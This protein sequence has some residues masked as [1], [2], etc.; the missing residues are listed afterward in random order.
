MQKTPKEDKTNR[1]RILKNKR[2]IINKGETTEPAGKGIASWW[3]CLLWLSDEEGTNS[4]YMTSQGTLAKYPYKHLLG[5]VST[6]E[7]LLKGIVQGVV[8]ITYSWGK[9]ARLCSHMVLRSDLL[10]HLSPSLMGLAFPNQTRSDIVASLYD[11]H[12]RQHRRFGYHG[13][14]VRLVRCHPR[15]EE[16]SATPLAWSR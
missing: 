2:D 7:K 14:D 15:L 5:R 13:R 10:Q 4:F 12:C 1:L 11:I 8:H 6:I 3:S 16:N 9:M